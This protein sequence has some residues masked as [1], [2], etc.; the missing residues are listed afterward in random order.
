MLQQQ[1]QAMGAMQ[2]RVEALSTVAS[3]HLPLRVIHCNTPWRTAKEMP[4][5][6]KLGPPA[7]RACSQGIASRG[8]LEVLSSCHSAY[9][10]RESS[11]IPQAL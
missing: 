2:A 1:R 11:K 6:V 10:D 3:T 4:L 5:S 8:W 9:E 7:S